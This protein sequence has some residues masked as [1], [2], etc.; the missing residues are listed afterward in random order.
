M[1]VEEREEELLRSVALQNAKSIETARQ[2]AEQDLL[3][4]KTELEARTEELA[5]SLA[6]MRATLESATDG[7]LVTDAVGGITTFNRQWHELWGIPPETLKAGRHAAVYEVLKHKFADPAKYVSR[8]KEIYSTSPPE[9]YDLLEL[10]DGRVFERFSRIQ[11]VEDRNVGRVWTIR[12]V[13]ERKRLEEVRFRLAA[14][15]ESSVDAIVSKKLDGTII[16]WN[17]GAERMFGYKADEI[18]GKP[19]TTL[20]PPDRLE[21]ETYIISRIRSGSRVE[22]YESVRVKKDGSLFDVSL[23]ISPVLDAQGSIVGASKIARDITEKKKAEEALRDSEERYRT[24]FASAP[25]AVFVCDKNAVIQQYNQR[26]AEFWGREPKCGV[27]K[28]CGSVKLWLPDGTL[29]PHDQS[30]VIGVLRTGESAYNVEVFIERPDASRL[31]VLVN[32]AAMKNAEGDI[33]GAITSFMD[34]AE[35]K[36]AEVALRESEARKA[37]IL[38]AALD[39]L[40]TMDHKGRVVDFNPAAEQTFGYRREDALN[41]SVAD[42]IIPDRLHEAHWKG[43]ERYL[44]TGKSNIL[45]QRIEVTARCADGREIPVEL[46][47]SVIDLEGRHPFFTA[48]L[49]DISERK[50]IEEERAQLLDAERAARS[51]AERISVMKDEFLANVSHELRTPLN[52]I[53]GWSQL[54]SSKK[55]SDEDVQ[56]GLETIRRN[57]R[58]QAQ[59]IEDLLDMSRIVS[60]KI[61]LDVQQLDLTSVVEGAVNSVRPSADAKGIRLRQIVDPSIGP[62]TGDP[63]RLQQVVWNLLSNAVKFTPKGGSVKVLLQRVNSHLE[64]TISDSGQGIKADFLPYVFERFRQ[65]DSS[66]TRMYGGLGLGLAI[67]KQLVE[68]HGGTVSATSEGEGL[69]AT[70]TVC[71]PLAPIR[72]R[73]VKRE[74]PATT[75]HT[76]SDCHGIDIT[77]VKVLVVDDELD[78]REV[79]R[80]MLMEC[81]AQVLIAANAQEGL[82]L[83]VSERPDVILSDIGMP[84]SDG[85]EFIREVR[86]LPGGSGGRTPAMAL[87]AFARTEDRTRAMIAG[88]QIHIAKPIEPQELLAA[89]ASLAG[90]MER[91]GD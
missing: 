12:D 77:G 84:G 19:V 23:T 75:T 68:L 87:T 15:V 64:I 22:H 82:K 1:G 57:A 47:I 26:A 86:R 56:Q 41:K 36:Q 31:P 10:S 74:H 71:L 58:A 37:G 53:L 4:A 76:F 14:I 88:Y 40:I 59:L 73:E 30:P 78:A 5:R 52:S 50:R 60:G 70:F 38:E 66:T 18:I 17:K 28:H 61:R 27:E 6:M 21:E 85:Y 63:T 2:R 91:G 24:L 54:I 13:T 8:I 72:S 69:G 39:C 3:E 48:Y 80:R 25:M 62:V 83:V 32:F 7:I 43:I 35:R 33:I 16:T 90:R 29:L 20:I 11:F 34:I 46:A 44:N 9:A 67:V 55:L 45:G 79:I 81:H 65:A 42:L 89:V 49:R 51:A